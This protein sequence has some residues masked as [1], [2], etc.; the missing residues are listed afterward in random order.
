ME[1]KHLTKIIYRIEPKPEGGFVARASDPSVP[2]LE[3]PTRE[4]LLQK[5][6]PKIFGK[7]AAEF[8]GLK[9]PLGN[10][11]T[12]VAVQIEGKPG[13]S[14]TFHS[15]D[16]RPSEE[17]VRNTKEIADLIA[18]NF[19]E[20]SQALA[21]RAADA[22]T[23]G[24]GDQQKEVVAAVGSPKLS[25]KMGTSLVPTGLAPAA[26][27]DGNSAEAAADVNVANAANTPIT[28]EAS[29]SWKVVGFLLVVLILAALVYFLRH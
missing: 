5:I 10:A 28:P 4:E 22:K 11:Q 13:T 23:F 1:L 25:L 18:K 24:N 17:D 8:P 14:F 15:G 27:E 7:L 16:A 20:I 9:L 29:S 21:A 19:P 3:A 12:K 2:P 26:A 6:Q